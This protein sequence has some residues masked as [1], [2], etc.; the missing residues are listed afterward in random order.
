MQNKISTR[1]A[2]IGFTIIVSIIFL[3][4]DF[5]FYNS[6]NSKTPK[7]ILFDSNIINLGLDLRGG[8]EFLLAPKLEEWLVEK[9]NNKELDQS[10]R[11]DFSSALLKADSILKK[12][13]KYILTIDKIE[14][15]Q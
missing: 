2:L 14:S 11:S 12:D 10:I 3:C 4:N 1:W 9:I 6:S 13:E 7:K 15:F 5:I 8:K